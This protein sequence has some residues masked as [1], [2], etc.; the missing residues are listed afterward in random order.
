[1]AARLDVAFSERELSLIRQLYGT[2][3]DSGK[4][5]DLAKMVGRSKTTIC[6][7]ARELGL[8]DQL[9]AKP[10]SSADHLQQMHAANGHPRG[11]LGKRH[12]AESRAAI[13][14]GG[15]EF[16]ANAGQD[17]HDER[18]MKS[19]RSKERAG[20]LVTPRM[21]TTWKAAWREIGGVRKFYRSKW[22]ANYAHYLQ[23]LKERAVI[24]DW[25]HEPKTFWFEGLKRGSVSYL[26]DFWVQEVGG[27]ESYH[28]VK[29]WMDDRSRVKLARMAKYHPEVRLIVIDRTAY[30]SLKK[31][32]AGIVPNWEQ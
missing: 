9:R 1:M 5:D 25:K 11:M 17:W 12:T 18:L 10:Y 21:G 31:K 8:T 2:Y 32:L 27:D 16:R 7:K 28:E 19:L 4:L 24:A 13:A 6:R 20:T 29:G 14:A 23:W 22:E 30:T 15:A 26:P 3:A